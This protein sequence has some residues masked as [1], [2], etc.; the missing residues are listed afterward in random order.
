M[1][2]HQKRVAKLQGIYAAVGLASIVAVFLAVAAIGWVSRYVGTWIG[3]FPMTW[4]ECGDMRARVCES[5]VY[6]GP[7]TL[8]GCFGWGVLSLV[9]LFAAAL[10]GFVLLLTLYNVL[11]SIGRFVAAA[12]QH[13]KEDV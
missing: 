5:V 7:E 4:P 6:H 10:L 11:L 8:W 1:S 2:A 3:V 13:R 12:W 9:M